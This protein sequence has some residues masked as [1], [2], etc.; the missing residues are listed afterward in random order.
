MMN[1][2]RIENGGLVLFVFLITL[3]LGAVVST[4]AVALLWSVLAAIL[5]QPLYQRIHA[6]FPERSN[7]AALLTKTGIRWR[8]WPPSAPCR[9]ILARCHP[10]QR[11]TISL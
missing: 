7:T 6:R 11:S 4:F 5:F 10:V 1:G 2:R 9:R 8:I 3:L